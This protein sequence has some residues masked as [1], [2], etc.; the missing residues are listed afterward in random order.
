[1]ENTKHILGIPCYTHSWNGMSINFLA[2]PKICV[3]ISDYLF[4]E[5]Y[6]R[7]GCFYHRWTFL[8]DELCYIQIGSLRIVL[9]GSFH[10]R[11]KII[12]MFQSKK[13][14]IIVAEGNNLSLLIFY[15]Q[16]DIYFL[17][18]N[19]WFIKL[20]Q[21]F[22]FILYFVFSIMLSNLILAQKGSFD[23]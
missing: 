18:L 12:S 16:K 10:E 23:F 13:L 15:L 1:M 20:D 6:F 11:F 22:I 7:R 5:A 14:I 8:Q 3:W 21:L 4:I 19:N 17:K 9:D 2:K